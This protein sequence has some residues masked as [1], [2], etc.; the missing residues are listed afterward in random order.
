VLETLLLE[1]FQKQFLSKVGVYFEL[2]RN[3]RFI[4]RE[5]EWSCTGMTRNQLE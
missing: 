3:G 1:Q 4:G 5:P 2:G